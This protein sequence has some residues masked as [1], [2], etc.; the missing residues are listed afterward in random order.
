MLRLRKIQPINVTLESSRLGRDIEPGSDV[1]LA[2][3]DDYSFM[4]IEVRVQHFETDEETITLAKK[5]AYD[6]IKR[7]AADA[8]QFD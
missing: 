8:P 6:L 7:L 3:E 4:T 2:A 5:T 1:T